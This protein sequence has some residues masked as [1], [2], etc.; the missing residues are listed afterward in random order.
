MQRSRSVY[1]IIVLLLALLIITATVGAYFYYQYT[2]EVS[3]SN[4][5]LKEL[6][7]ANPLIISNIFMDFGNGTQH[8]YNNTRVQP[9]WNL[10]VA[11]LSLT[12]GNVNA[13]L[14]G[15]PLNEH[16]VTGIDGVQNSKTTSWFLWTWNSTASWQVANVGPDLL[17]M[18]NQSV[19]AWTFCG[20]DSNY[21]PTCTPP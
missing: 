14:Y 8:W 6:Q 20:M 21:N 19:Y 1:G 9:G 11:T 13:T 18:Y 2:Q 16:F 3:V 15:P 10:Y 5:Y 12:N 4:N 7:A 17:R